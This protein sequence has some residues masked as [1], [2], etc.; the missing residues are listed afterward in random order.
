[1]RRS[2]LGAPAPPVIPLLAN[3]GQPTTGASF[4]VNLSGARAS[5]TAVLLTGTSKTAWS[6]IP[7]P[8]NLGGVG[9]P[10]CNLLV[11]ADF[12]A[13]AATSAVGGATIP[14]SIPNDASL[15]SGKF[16]QQFT[17]VDAGANALG[18][19]F[20]RGGEGTIGNL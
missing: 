14:V 6:G 8:F 12:L 7:L 13:V 11:S 5:S 19:A 16:Y 17:V 2:G 1:M 15:L 3:T 4:S 20:T 9:A 18:Y 10:Q